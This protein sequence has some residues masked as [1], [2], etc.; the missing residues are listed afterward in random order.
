MKAIVVTNWEYF[1]G[2]EELAEVWLFEDDVD[3]DELQDGWD[4][5]RPKTKLHEYM[6]ARNG[7]LVE[8]DILEK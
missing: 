8:F 1:G 3:I 6:N 7:V 4:K 5:C 2:R